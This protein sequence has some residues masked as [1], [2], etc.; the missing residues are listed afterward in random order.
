MRGANL[1]PESFDVD[2]DAVERAVDANTRLVFLC[3]P[4]NP[5][6]DKCLGRRLNGYWLRPSYNEQ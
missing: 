6:L 2:V 1:L 5:P 4:G 3:S